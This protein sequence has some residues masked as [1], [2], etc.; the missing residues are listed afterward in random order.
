MDGIV[1]VDKPAG[2]TSFDVVAKC[3]GILMEKKIGHGGT[4]DPMATGVLPLFLGRGTSAVDITFDQRKGYEAGFVLGVTTDTYDSTGTVVTRKSPEGITLAD[5][6]AELPAFCGEITQLPPMYSAVKINGQRL[7]KM[8]RHGREV[9]RPTKQV[10]VYELSVAQTQEGFSLSAL[11]S[12]GTFIRCIIH[13][14][15]QRLGCGAMMTC[16]TRTRACG[17]TLAD[18]VTLDDLQRSRDEKD[19][20]RHL[21]PLSRAFDGMPRLVF[22]GEALRR[23]VNGAPVPCEDGREDGTYT[24]WRADSFLG[25]AE[26]Q[27]GLIFTKKLFTDP[28][29]VPI[30]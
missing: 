11:C 16:L 22:S 4:L 23:F 1:C 24:A 2:F 21:L 6:R 27:S 10:C 15:G 30:L 8:A 5:I 20:T 19:L 14:L 12:K 29:K 28:H 18:C 26:I 17:F 13:D 7:Y 25:L 3:R 9:E